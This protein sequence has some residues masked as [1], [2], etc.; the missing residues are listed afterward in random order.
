MNSLTNISIL[1]MIKVSFI[2]VIFMVFTNPIADGQPYKTGFVSVNKTSFELNGKPYYFLGTNFWYGLNLGSKRTGGNRERLLRELDRLKNAGA[3]NLRIMAGSE[4]PDNSSWRMAPALQSAPGKY[5]AEVLDGLDFLLAEMKKRDMHAVMCL[6][7]FWPWSGGMSQYLIWAGAADSIPYPPP[8]PGGKWR[9]YAEFTARFYSNDRAKELFNDH[10]RFILNRKNRYTGLKYK[11][12]PVIM[13]WELANEPRGVNNIDSFL[14]WIDSTAGL[15]KQLDPNHLVTTGSE[16]ATSD[17]GNSGTDPYKDHSSKHI[18]YM[19]A[20]LWVQNWGFYNPRKADLTYPASVKYALKYISEHEKEAQRLSKPLVL[21]E[22]GISRD[23]NSCEP[24]SPVH[25]RDDYYKK[26]FEII[27]EKAGREAGVISGCN[28]WAWG[29]EGRPRKP[30]QF[31][32]A[33]DD[34]TGDPA[35]EPQGWYSVFD[36]DLSTIVIIKEYAARMRNLKN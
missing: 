30:G 3:D 20:H 13:A 29:G 4:G 27:F 6:T 15:I 21:E 23:L 31:W 26:V 10:I 11:N 36:N 24:A 18:D 9:S 22:F 25:I 16:G 34:F 8:H 28:F 35:H 7:N 5:N 33:G 12:D 14:K 2:L 19:T 32:Q 1:Q 17:P